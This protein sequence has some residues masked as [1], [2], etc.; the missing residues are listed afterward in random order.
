MYLFSNLFFL[1]TQNKNEI[2]NGNGDGK[3]N[4]QE[5]YLKIERELLQFRKYAFKHARFKFLLIWKFNKFTEFYYLVNLYSSSILYIFYVFGVYRGPLY[6][7]N[8]IV[9]TTILKIKC[10]TYFFT[11]CIK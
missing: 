4:F 10:S 3:N 8:F 11:A 9:R 1:I 7:G 5:V 2:K 6:R